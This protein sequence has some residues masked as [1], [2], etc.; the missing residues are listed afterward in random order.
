MKFNVAQLLKGSSGASL[1]Y[2]LNEDITWIDDDLEILAPLVGRII[3]TRTVSG[4]LVTGHAGTMMRTACPRC[5]EA[6]DWEVDF[7]L[8]EEFVSAVDIR[9]GAS[10]PIP[11][12]VDP[13]LVIDECH[14]LD[15]AEPVRQYLVIAQ[16]TCPPCRADC[17]GLCPECGQNL[18]LGQ[19]QCSETVT[20]ER[21]AALRALL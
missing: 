11:E 3:L 16:T 6:Y 17:A 10:L 12:D 13:G 19:C 21:L 8:E 5:L 15:L 20:D 1:S 14:V 18:N 2:D 4:V 7:E 9:T